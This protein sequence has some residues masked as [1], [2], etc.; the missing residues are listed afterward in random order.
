MNTQLKLSKKEVQ[1]I[2]CI[3][4]GVE[5]VET[6]LK[7][8]LEKQQ[9]EKER[10]NL[11]R[12]ECYEIL[13][14]IGPFWKESILLA[15]AS[16][17][18]FLYNNCDGVNG[19]KLW[20]SYAVQQYTQWQGQIQTIMGDI[21]KSI[22]QNQYGSSSFVVQ[23]LLNGSEIQKYLPNIPKGKGFH[24]V[25]RAQEKWQVT[26]MMLPS[27]SDDLKDNIRDGR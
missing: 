8:V 20:S 12:W 23:R 7:A 15:F 14:H 11:L 19:S 27:L 1:S 3:I 9:D 25:M 4:K 18:T 5:I 22:S 10:P 17:P 6:K 21:I 26:N 13:Q 2:E 24:T 16:S